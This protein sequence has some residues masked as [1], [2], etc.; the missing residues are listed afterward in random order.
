MQAVI[1]AG[2]LGTRMKKFLQGKPKCLAPF[3]GKTILEHQLIELNDTKIK[4]VLIVCC[5]RAEMVEEYISRIRHN[6]NLDISIYIEENLGGTGGSLLKAF[7]QLDDEFILIMGDLFFSINLEKIFKYGKKLNSKVLLVCKYTDHPFDSD[8]IGIGENQ[9]LKNFYLRES[10]RTQKMN[11]LVPPLGNSGIFYFQKEF[12]IDNCTKNCD[13]HSV[14]FEF[15]KK[16]RS[17]SQ[18]I[19]YYYTSEFVRDIG[20]ESRLKNT[21]LVNLIPSQIKSNLRY[22]AI[23]LDKDNT[24]IPDTKDSN[25]RNIMINLYKKG[26]IK[27]LQKYTSTHRIFITTNQPGISK[28]FFLEEDL[29]IHLF[30][31]GEAL[32]RENIYISGFYFCPHHPNKGYKNE[33]QSLKISCDCRKPKPGMIDN[34]CKE[35][36][37]DLAKSIVIGDSSRDEE[38]AKNVGIDFINAAQIR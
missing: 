28:G 22:P 37:T 19:N 25:P 15:I 24:I 2:G 32:F 34:I 17:N 20:S 27:I 16:N 11:G 38:L 30:N 26:I 29:L 35:Y 33:I 36:N 5:Y 3:R 13:I 9:I 6:L 1:L 7:D 4:K 12:I 14:I 18:F 10:D 8:L 31:L 23:F 21:A